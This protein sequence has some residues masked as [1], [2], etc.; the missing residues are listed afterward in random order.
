MELKNI[1]FYPLKKHKKKIVSLI[2]FFTL[3]SVYM[4]VKIGI[5]S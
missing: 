5:V 4:Q 1:Y 2:L 3:V